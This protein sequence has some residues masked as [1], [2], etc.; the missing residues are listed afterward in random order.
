MDAG[1]HQRAQSIIN[2]AMSG[3]PPQALEAF[4]ADPH[5]EV[6]SLAGPLVTGVQVTV[7]AHRELR[8]LQR[9]AQDLF[10]LTGADRAG[11]RRG[12]AVAHRHS[13][14]PADLPDAKEMAAELMQ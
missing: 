4:A 7:V 8:G 10:N 6:A 5:S 11:R 3:H 2:E 13:R 1:I 9:G 14:G 12:R